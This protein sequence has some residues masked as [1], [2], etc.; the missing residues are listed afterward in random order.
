MPW[1]AIR[2]TR[3]RVGHEY[4][5]T[6]PELIWAALATETPDYRTFVIGLLGSGD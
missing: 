3:N 4:P 1:A 6:D 2:G 5:L